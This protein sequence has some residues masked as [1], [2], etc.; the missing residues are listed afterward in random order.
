MNALHKKRL[1]TK[2]RVR[3]KL[4]G[5]QDRPRV[6]IYRSNMHIS[7][8]AINDDASVSI[9]G[10]SC[11]SLKL[12]G[13]TKTQEAKALGLAMGKRLKEL[14]ITS[15]LFDRGYYKYTGRVAAFADGLREATITV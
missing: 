1:R 11:T 15:A 5:T 3:A 9:V 7:A 2:R 14:K 6:S 8:Q 4:H 12:T 13:V 10:M